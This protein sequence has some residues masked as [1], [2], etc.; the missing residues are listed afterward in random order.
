[1]CILADAFHVNS[2][3]VVEAYKLLFLCPDFFKIRDAYITQKYHFQIQGC[4]H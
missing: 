4:R 2:E 3:W 1:M